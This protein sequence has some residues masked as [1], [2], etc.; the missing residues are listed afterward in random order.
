MKTIREIVDALN[1][2]ENLEEEEYFLVLEALNNL[3]DECGLELDTDVESTLGL[4]DYD[5]EDDDDED[6]EDEEDDY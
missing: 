3:A 4:D 5:D 2:L 6:E 1:A